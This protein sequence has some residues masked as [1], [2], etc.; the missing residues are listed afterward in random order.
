MKK[1]FQRGMYASVFMAVIEILLLVGCIHTDGRFDPRQPL[2]AVLIGCILLSVCSAVVLRRRIRVIDEAGEGSDPDFW[3]MRDRRLHPMRFLIAAAAAAAVIVLCIAVL[4][5]MMLAD[6]GFDPE[7]P[8]YYVC[9]G[10]IA[11]VILSVVIGV[12]KRRP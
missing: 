11:F 4:I 3:M 1:R 7:E 9:F 2:N 6:H 5:R 8:L 12:N 10:I